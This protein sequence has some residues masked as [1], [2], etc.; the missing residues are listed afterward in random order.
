MRDKAGCLRNRKEATKGVIWE[1]RE[2]RETMQRLEGHV[3]DLDFM[4]RA[5][6]ARASEAGAWQ[7]LIYLFL[8]ITCCRMENSCE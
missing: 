5:V 2:Q 3:R 4:P 7:D 6:A 1:R 8:K